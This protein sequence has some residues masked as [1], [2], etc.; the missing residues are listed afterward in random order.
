VILEKHFSSY[1]QATHVVPI[2][3][4][5]TLMVHGILPTQLKFGVHGQTQNSI[6]ENSQQYEASEVKVR[7]LHVFNTV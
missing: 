6:V 7:Q 3:T 1:R 4:R 2:N 5:L